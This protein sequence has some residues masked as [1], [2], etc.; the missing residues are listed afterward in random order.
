MSWSAVILSYNHEDLTRRCVQSVLQN[1][2]GQIFLIHNGSRLSIVEKLRATFPQVKHCVLQKNLGF[3][4]GANIGLHEAFQGES[5]KLLFMTNDTVLEKMDYEEDEGFLLAPRI[6][7]RKTGEIDSWGGHAD[8]W[9]GQLR[10]CRGVPDHHAFKKGFYVPGAAFLLDKK[11]W[12]AA[13]PF[14]ETLG[15]YWEDVDFSLRAKK[16]GIRLGMTSKITLRHGIGK[17]CHGDPLYT[18]YYF[19]RNRRKVIWRHANGFEKI[20]FGLVYAWDVGR[21]ILKLTLKRDTKRLT[22]LMRAV[23]PFS[24][25]PT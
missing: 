17:T 11:A 12:Q 15:T 7:K 20:I 5:Q 24:P 10:H 1:F 16:K 22:L 3:T 21:K 2:S 13:G 6:F 8:L 9:T 25:K 23:S 14:D 18:V 4:G 19:Y